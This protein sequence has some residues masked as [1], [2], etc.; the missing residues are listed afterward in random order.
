[1]I[2]F[3]VEAAIDI[4]QNRKV[5]ITGSAQASVEALEETGIPTIVD[6]LA[7]SVTGQAVAAYEH[8]IPRIAG[9]GGKGREAA[10][11]RGES[12]EIEPTATFGEDD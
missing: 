12:P 1:M 7:E 3:K 10:R 11:L 4:D 8:A 6:A 2:T 5:W 9:D